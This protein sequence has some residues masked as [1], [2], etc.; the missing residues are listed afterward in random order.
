MIGFTK[1]QMLEKTAQWIQANETWMNTEMQKA[2]R[3]VS[4]P[5]EALDK[6]M[7]FNLRV[8]VPEAISSLLEEQ[9]KLMA[10][11]IEAM[12]DEKIKSAI[13]KGNS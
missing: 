3:G 13:N 7:V 9:N 4:H 1:Q 12:I 8:I 11:Q 2:V 6:A 10:Q 5:M